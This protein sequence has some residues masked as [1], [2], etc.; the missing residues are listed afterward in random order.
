MRLK[1]P[2]NLRTVSLNLNF[3]VFIK[4]FIRCY[5]PQFATNIVA[6][7]IAAFAFGYKTTFSEERLLQLRVQFWPA[8]KLNFRPSAL[9]ASTAT[10]S[11]DAEKLEIA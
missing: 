2:E 6:P 3:T 9:D 11:L 5:V 10:T 8:W 1:I 4:K 7:S